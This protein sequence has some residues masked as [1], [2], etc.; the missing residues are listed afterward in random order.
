MVFSLFFKLLN[1]YD[2]LTLQVTPWTSFMSTSNI[3]DNA[4]SIPILQRKPLNL[5]QCNFSQMQN[6]Q[7]FPTSDMQH[8]PW[9]KPR[10]SIGHMHN[11]ISGTVWLAYDIMMG[12]L[13]WIILTTYPRKTLHLQYTQ[14]Y[15]CSYTIQ[16]SWYKSHFHHMGASY[17]H[18]CL[19]RWTAL[20]LLYMIHCKYVLYLHR[21]CHLQSILCCKCMNSSLLSFYKLRHYRKDC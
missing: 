18:Q 9:H 4:I 7:G 12:L 10:R 3:V 11:V 6:F 19:K 1:I 14:H 17:I 2:I 21:I 5:W 15:R 13:S 20:Y 8:T 16:C